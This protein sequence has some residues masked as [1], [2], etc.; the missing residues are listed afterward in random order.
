MRIYKSPTSADSPKCRSCRVR[1]H[2]GVVN[3]YG[4]GCRCEPCCSM[5]RAAKLAYTEKVLA[6]DGLT[7][8][9]LARPS[10]PKSC[11]TCGRSIPGSPVSTY[12]G[13]CGRVVTAKKRNHRKRARN[14]PKIAQR[15]LD[16]AA[17]GTIASPKWPWVQG[18]CAKCGEY[19]VRKG[20]SSAYCSSK[21]SSR[22]PKQKW[23]GKARRLSIYARD[24]WICQICKR[25]VDPAAPANTPF[26]ASLDHIE[27]RS[28]VLIPD[29]SDRNLRLAHMICNTRRGNSI[30]WEVSD[31]WPELISA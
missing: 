26:A 18:V 10:K 22:K 15:K 7:P 28:L 14:R 8:T 30:E 31:L 9:Q 12:C 4:K 25:S 17:R 20:D 11:A 23:I 6:R 16:K 13:P 24:G 1:L 29:H 27:P 21:C 3:R 2:A 19:F 5:Q